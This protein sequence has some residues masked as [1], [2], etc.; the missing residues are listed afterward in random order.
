MAVEL[1]AALARA[2]L[3]ET[4][5]RAVTRIVALLESELGEDL[6]AV[7]L[8]GSRARGEADPDETHYDR[9]SDIDMMAIV[10]PRRD[11]DS[12]KWDFTPKMID[13][14]AA[15]GDSPPYYSM[16]MY[17]AD[18]LRNRRQIRSFFFQEV[19]RD[20]IVLAG[21]DLEEDEYK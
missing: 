4:E 21:G 15:E 10:D 11:V 12:F 6:L 3:N 7:W 18:W 14:V 17:D 2:A 9:R 5:R 20:K 1:S 16:H 13:A 8:Y 19:D